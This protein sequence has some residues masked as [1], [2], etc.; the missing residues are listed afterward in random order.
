MQ[1]CCMLTSD[2]TDSSAP[3]CRC[4]SFL[5]GWMCWSWWRTRCGGAQH[6]PSCLLQLLGVVA[7]VSRSFRLPCAAMGCHTLTHGR[8]SSSSRSCAASSARASHAC[9]VKPDHYMYQAQNVGSRSLQCISSCRRGPSDS[10]EGQH[11]QVLL[12]LIKQVCANCACLLEHVIDDCICKSKRK[13]QT[14]FVWHC[15]AQMA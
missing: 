10:D 1:L 3:C 8:P 2:L 11:I 7:A 4:W 15:R 9:N 6:C 14:E 12:M 13:S 5:P